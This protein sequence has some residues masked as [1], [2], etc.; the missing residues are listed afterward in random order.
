MG[1]PVK[2]PLF[3]VRRSPVAGLGVF[4]LRR[5]RKGTRIV[6]YVGERISTEE[7]DTRYDDDAM[8]QHHTMLF[9]VDDDTVIDAAVDGNE[10]R[11]VNHS[12]APNCEAVNE[13]GRIFIEAIA[14]IPVGAELFY[15]Y[16]LTREEPWDD[17]W[18]ELY[19]CRCGA[20]ACRGTILKSPTPP[21]RKKRK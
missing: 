6:E 13:S 10:A 21:R 11:F 4:A 12:C 14:D 8:E 17:R 18:L 9:A 3:E 5:I 15:D 7:A 20:S 1:R 19:A 16:G 2:K